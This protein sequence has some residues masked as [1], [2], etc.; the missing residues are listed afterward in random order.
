M[1]FKNQQ[2]FC[3]FLR[4]CRKLKVARVKVGEIEVE[5][6]HFTEKTL[7]SRGRQTRRDPATGQNEVNEA[8]KDLHLAQIAIDDPEA[9]EQLSIRGLNGE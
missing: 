4:R 8:V 7:Q 2:D 9:F 5:F 1:T 6:T 3:N